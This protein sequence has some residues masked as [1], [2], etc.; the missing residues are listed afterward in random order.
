MALLLLLFT[1]GFVMS[2]RWLDSKIISA[3]TA[4]RNSPSSESAGGVDIVFALCRKN[5]HRSS[6]ILSD[7]T[8]MVSQVH[9]FY[10]VRYRRNNDSGT[11]ILSCQVSQV[12]S[13]NLIRYHRHG[14]SGHSFYLV[15]YM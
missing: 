12:Q 4:E 13:F 9:S 10:I 7:I 6:F 2:S 11:T 1:V 3:K 8:C 15:R 5:H 14:I